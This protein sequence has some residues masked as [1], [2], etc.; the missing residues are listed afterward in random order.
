MA[1]E[2]RGFRSAD[3]SLLLNTRAVARPRGV[4]FRV[5]PRL[6][7]KTA[8][9]WGTRRLESLEFAVEA[10]WVPTLVAFVATVWGS[11]ELMP[12][13]VKPGCKRKLLDTRISREVNRAPIGIK[14]RTPRQVFVQVISKID[15]LAPMISFAERN[16]Q[17]PQTAFHPA[18]VE[19]N[20]RLIGCYRR[21]VDRFCRIA[22][23]YKFRRKIHPVLELRSPE[24]HGLGGCV[25]S[26]EVQ[27]PVRGEA[28][29]IDEHI[30]V[31]RGA[32]PDR[33]TPLVFVSTIPL[34][35]NSPNIC[36]RPRPACKII[37]RKRLAA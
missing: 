19:H 22:E 28:R 9:T 29:E 4:S 13:R 1:R 17:A 12:V 10:P 14:M 16:A 5:D 31:N 32:D 11:P 18:I 37:L 15:A 20:E 23:R 21:V 25:K 35:I 24:M 34:A 2:G 8:R 7:P 3:T 27:R 26:H 6:A 36:S 33:I 30:A